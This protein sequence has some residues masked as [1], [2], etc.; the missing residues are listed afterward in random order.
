MTER[1][2]HKNPT[3][4]PSMSLDADVVEAVKELRSAIR[5]ADTLDDVKRRVRGRPDSEVKQVLRRWEKGRA[6]LTKARAD[7]DAVLLGDAADTDDDAG[8]EEPQTAEAS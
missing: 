3:Q 8:D 4:L 6:A 7:L 5:K 2:H 1:S